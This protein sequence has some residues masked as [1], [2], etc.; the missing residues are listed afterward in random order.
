[1]LDTGETISFDALVIGCGVSPRSPVDAVLG[2]GK[3]QFERGEDGGLKVDRRME[4]VGVEGVYAAGD[5]CDLEEVGHNQSRSDE[6]R[7]RV[8]GRPSCGAVTSHRLAASLSV[9]KD[10]YSQLVSLRSTS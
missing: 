6:L 7:K 8:L 1:M 2:A 9:S 3:T 4:C 10:H 5:C